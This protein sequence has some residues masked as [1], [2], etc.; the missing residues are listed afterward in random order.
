M[1]INNVKEL[2][3]IIKKGE[4]FIADFQKGYARLLVEVGD[5]FCGSHLGANFSS[6]LIK[7]R[8]RKI[9][10]ETLLSLNDD[11]M[12]SAEISARIDVE[13]AYM[14]EGQDR[15]II[16]VVKMEGVYLDVSLGS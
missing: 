3:E 2:F 10:G 13:K 16:P 4:E 5:G 7:I 11:M 6:A 12:R 15:M 9:S 8:L 1:K 14:I